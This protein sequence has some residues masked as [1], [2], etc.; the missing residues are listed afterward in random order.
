[1][2]TIAAFNSLLKSF[3]VE[4]NTC[5]GPEHPE[6]KTYLDGFD[7]FVGI[8][9][10]TPLNMF[11][12]AVGPHADLLSRKDPALFEQ[13]S[14]NLGG[15]I[16][17]KAIWHTPD[18]SEATKEAIFSYLST[19][20]LLG[21]TVCCLPPQLL[22]NI[23]DAAQKTAENFKSGNMSFASIASQLTNIMGPV[24][25]GSLEQF[26]GLDQLGAANTQ[27]GTGADAPK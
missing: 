14:L 27:G 17:I 21:S 3:I 13:E 4:L 2:T 24:L 5:F 10:R 26:G 23:E 16:D 8:S 12:A 11:M 1:M 19:L 20:W 15:N 9:P 6:L 7:A 25:S 18:V 22:E